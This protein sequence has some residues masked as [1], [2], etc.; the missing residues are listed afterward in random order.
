VAPQLLQLTSPETNT[1]AVLGAGIHAVRNQARSR[2]GFGDVDCESVSALQAI[3][4]SLH[5]D[6]HVCPTPS[7]LNHIVQRTEWLAQGTRAR[8]GSAPSRI[9]LRDGTF[10]RGGF[11]DQA[12]YTDQDSADL[13]IIFSTLPDGNIPGTTRSAPILDGEPRDRRRAASTAGSWRPAALPVACLHG[14]HE[15]FV[16]SRPRASGERGHEGYA[17]QFDPQGDDDRLE[18]Y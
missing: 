12:C 10:G 5:E 1:L 18:R 9:P 3:V 11:M 13:G 7:S 16:S 14:G 17:Q 2:L 15:I 8:E 6:C 4:V